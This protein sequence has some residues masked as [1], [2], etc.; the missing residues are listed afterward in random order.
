MKLGMVHLEKGRPGYIRAISQ[1]M[2]GRCLA[3][4]DVEVSGPMTPARAARIARLIAFG[5]GHG[6]ETL[7]IGASSAWAVRAAPARAP[8][9]VALEAVL[10]GY[11]DDGR[12]A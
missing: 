8:L 10:P 11:V 6:A 5:L 1:D 12:L 2:L 7:E 9:G 3:H 4:L